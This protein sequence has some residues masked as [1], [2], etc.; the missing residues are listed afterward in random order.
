MTADGA[1]HFICT[2]WRHIGEVLAAAGDLFTGLKNLCVW[3]KITGGM[4]SL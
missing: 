4:G 1:V 3:A 2:D